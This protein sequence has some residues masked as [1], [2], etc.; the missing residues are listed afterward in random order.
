VKELEKSF[1]AP[2][3]AAPV[4]KINWVARS[5]YEGVSSGFWPSRGGMFSEALPSLLV[6]YQV[7]QRP[8]W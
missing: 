7:M 6:V 5:S 1:A 2:T 3:G 8:H 4:A